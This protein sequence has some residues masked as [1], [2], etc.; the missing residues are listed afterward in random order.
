M[1][2]IIVTLLMV[3]TLVFTTTGQ[4]LSLDD[5]KAYAINNNKNL[6]NAHLELAAA[7]KIKQNA[8]TNYFP[9]VDAGAF[10]MKSSSKMIQ[11]E[12]PEI[13]L[14]V[15]D[16]NLASIPGST[17]YAYIPGMDIGIMDYLSTGYITA[18]QP[19]FAGGRI[20]N[21]NKLAEL[22][23]SIKSKQLNITTEEVLLKTE[24]LYWTIISLTEKKNT[25]RGYETLLHSF[26]KDALVSFDAG[27]IQKSDVLKIELELNKIEAQKLQLDNG[28]TMVKMALSQHIGI[29]YSENLN[30]TDTSLIINTP[31]S[32]FV[33][34][35]EALMNRNEYK[36]LNQTVTA[37]ELQQKI[38]QGE[39]LPS[40]GIGVSGYYLD[41]MDNQNTNTM[42]FATLSIPISGWWGGSYKNK[43]H[44]IKV[45][46][47]QNNFFQKS[48]LLQLQ[49]EQ[50]FRDLS[51]SFQQIEVAEATVSQAKEYYFEINNG[52]NA[53]IESTTN[54][55]EA[56]ALLQQANDT[57]IDAKAGY[58]IKLA[59]YLQATS[60]TKIN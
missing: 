23:T 44:K 10:T 16:G 3:S 57:L 41:M 46:I 22:G 59:Y 28:L 35:Q 19:I 12:T 40:V 14:P 37:E 56:R 52:F 11:A 39:Y 50:T 25:L 55:L 51:E 21:G 8:F 27:L 30:L 1:K 4:N 48:E 13:N 32:V 33:T 7:Q 47:A 31:L 45:E 34:P 20:Y 38:A 6:K 53:G 17:E 54:L 42:A 60:Q 58:K 9:K 43:E 5:C 26:K 2:H 15:Y 49:I 18:I 36:I 24:S 29:P